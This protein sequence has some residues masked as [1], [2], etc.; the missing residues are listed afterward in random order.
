MSSFHRIHLYLIFEKLTLKLFSKI[1]LDELSFQSSSNQIFA[2]YT[3]SKNQVRIWINLTFM[4]SSSNLISTACL[5]CKAQVRNV[6]KIKLIQIH[7][8]NSIF[9][10]S[11]TD[12]QGKI[13]FQT[14]QY[15][16]FLQGLDF[17]KSNN[18]H[19]QFYKNKIHG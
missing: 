1:K 11:S 6:P 4:Q 14:R 13:I 3:G 16:K 2:G 9:Q 15:F 19:S 5:A 8:P 12:Q 7:F 10:K 18:T 17:L